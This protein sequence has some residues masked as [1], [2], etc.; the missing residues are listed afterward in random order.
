MKRLLITLMIMG[1]A[2]TASQAQSILRRL[3]RAAKSAAERTAER[4]VEEK[5]EEG[6]SKA[7]DKAFEETEEEEK[8]SKAESAGEKDKDKHARS[9]SR[10]A[11][12]NQD[13]Q[14]DDWDMDEEDVAMMKRTG[15]SGSYSRSGDS[16]TASRNSGTAQGRS[17]GTAPGQSSGS[18][19]GQS[20]GSVSGDPSRRASGS[21]SGQES[22]QNRR[23]TMEWAK[24]DFVAGDE[25]FFEDNLTGEK[26]G[27]F[28]SRWDIIEGNAEVVKIDGENA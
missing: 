15:R 17:S 8:E 21:A 16:G 23:A 9:S 7:I 27:E 18:A 14:Y 22:P 20:S 13:L 10:K 3:E 24:S 26:L 1:L 2:C 4:K 5:V 25:I 12:E 11:P 28:P 6:V 19:S